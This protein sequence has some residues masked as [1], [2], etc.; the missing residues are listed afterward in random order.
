MGI[1]GGYSW[2]TRDW[3]SN[4]FRGAKFSAGSTILLPDRTGFAYK[5]SAGTTCSRFY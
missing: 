1:R 5:L 3:W 2:W 4:I